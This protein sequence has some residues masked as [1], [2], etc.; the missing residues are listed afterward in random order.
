MVAVVRVDAE[1]VDDLEVVLA[2][3]FDVDQ[4]VV[5]RRAIV[6]GECVDVAHSLGRRKD[7]WRDDFVQ[8]AGELRVCQADVVERFELFTKVLLERSTVANVLA[9]F[10]LQAS[11]FFDELVFKLVFWCG[12]GNVETEF[13]PV[14]RGFRRPR[15]FS[16]HDTARRGADATETGWKRGANL[17]WAA[18]AGD[19]FSRNAGTVVPKPSRRVLACP[20]SLCFHWYEHF[21]RFERMLADDSRFVTV[22]WVTESRAVYPPCTHVT[23]GFV[24]DV[25][26]RVSWPGGPRTWPPVD[27]IV[28]TGQSPVRFGRCVLSEWGTPEPSCNHDQHRR[29]PAN[30]LLKPDSA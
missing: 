14:W 20:H 16:G 19:H 21:K 13:V 17:D 3:V 28:P 18:N 12:H 29:R 1:L 25:G 5:Q 6:A 11:K 10:V 30:S 23:R 22:F 27:A 24:R 26:S 8:Q 15:R 7:I 2:P 9:I 4:R